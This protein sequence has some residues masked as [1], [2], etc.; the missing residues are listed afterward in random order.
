VWYHVNYSTADLLA[1]GLGQGCDFVNK[2]C[3]SWSA[4]LGY[5]WGECEEVGCVVPS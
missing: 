2:S 5:V 4:D 1:W 3:A